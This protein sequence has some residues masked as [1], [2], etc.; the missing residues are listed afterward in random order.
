MDISLHYYKTGCGPSLIL[1]HGNGESSEYFVHQIDMFA[2]S[3][4][5]YAIDTR[6]HGQSPL[7]T[8]PFSLYQFADDLLDFMDEQEM[9]RADIL[10]FSDGGNIALLFALEHPERVRRLI[11]NSANLYPEGLTDSLMD[12][13]LPRYYE[14]RESENP[15]QQFEAALLA[16]MINEPHID[17]ADLNRL[18]M[19]T[20]VIA[21]DDDVIRPEHTQLIA[22]ALPNAWLT[23]LPGDHEIAYKDP[24]AFNR[25]VE[26]F[27]YGTANAVFLEE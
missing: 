14:I 3:F 19:P 26:R 16:L 15:A 27:L 4:T 22:E 7:G 11:L 5:V 24:D 12:A 1:L 21:G 9:D 20:L 6:G 8:A 10:G 18:I 25:E 23:I 2:Q 17:P 13:I